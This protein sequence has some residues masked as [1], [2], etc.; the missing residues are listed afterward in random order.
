MKETVELTA[1][2]A[3]PACSYEGWYERQL[4]CMR[5]IH[6][7]FPPLARMSTG[8]IFAFLILAMSG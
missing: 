8:T 6:P 1:L 4:Q 7:V 2:Y 5:C 3:I